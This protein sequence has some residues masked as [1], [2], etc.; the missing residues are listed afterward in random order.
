MLE[1]IEDL[2][3]GVIGFRA[4]GELTADDYDRVLI[5]AVEQ[6]LEEHEKVR[7][8]YVLGDGF[9]GVTSGAMWDDTKLGMAHITKWEKLALVS[10]VDWLRHAVVLLGYLMPGHMKAFTTAELDDARAWVVE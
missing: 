4:T 9:E 1:R 10:D 8:L 5:P 7:M 3:E 2:P 6:A